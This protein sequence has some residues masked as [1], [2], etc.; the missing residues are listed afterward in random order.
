MKRL[1]ERLE[2][3][4]RALS[5]LEEA[6]ERNGEPTELEVD[7]I[8]QRFEFIFELAWKCMKDY[9][10][11][12][13]VLFSLGSPRDVIQRAFQYHLIEEGESWIKMMIS[14]NDLSHLYDDMK[15]R[16]IYTCIKNEY[17]KLLKELVVKLFDIQK[18]N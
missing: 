6:I 13:G 14:R 5:R 1:E 3:Y 10:E 16:E 7:G 2:D 8:L 18:E 17:L 4:S 11:K 12:E 9:L 15:S